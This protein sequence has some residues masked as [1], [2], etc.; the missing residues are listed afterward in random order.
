M[1]SQVATSLAPCLISVLGVHEFLLVTFPG[2]ANRSRFCS[3]AHR[4][5][6][7]VPEFSLAS[8]TRTATLSPLRIRFRRGKFCGAGNVPMGFSVTIAPP[9]ASISS[10]SF[11]FSFGYTTSMPVPQTATVGMRAASAP[12]CAQESIPRAIPL[13]IRSRRTAKSRD[14]ISAIPDP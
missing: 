6:T 8:T 2:T 4:A 1:S 7:R 9:P 10:A 14:S 12:R 13:T 11:L 5:V 3:A